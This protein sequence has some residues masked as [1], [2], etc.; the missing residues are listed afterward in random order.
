MDPAAFARAVVAAFAG[1]GIRVLLRRAR[2]CR[3]PR[4]GASLRELLDATQMIGA[5]RWRNPARSGTQPC[6]MPS[7]T[8]VFT[9]LAS[10]AS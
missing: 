8:T 6:G 5:P 10:N 7:G 9:R 1:S 4:G 3:D 2:Q